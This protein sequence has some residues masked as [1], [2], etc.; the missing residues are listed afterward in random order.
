MAH[1]YNY[2]SALIQMADFACQAAKYFDNVVNNFD[3]S[4]LAKKIEELHQIENK[5]DEKRHEIIQNLAKEFLPPIEREDIVELAS[6]LDDIIDGID[7]VLQH[8][9]LYNIEKL[10]PECKDFSKLVVQ[11]CESIKSIADEFNNF[12]KSPTILANIIHTNKL[13]GEG[14]RLY[15][16][17]MRKIFTSDISVKEVFI[18]KNIVM[19]FENCCDYC[20][21]SAALFEIAI[22][23]N[24]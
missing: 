9:Y 16:E 22:I 5:A 2:F 1:K 21:Q 18:W 19:L 11:C 15:A 24:S 14:D 6:K 4:Q 10:L 12:R 20:E 7:D 23:K 13:E 8:F 17:M 3:T